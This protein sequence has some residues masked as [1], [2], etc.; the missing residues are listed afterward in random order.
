MREEKKI[1]KTHW[2]KGENGGTTRQSVGGPRTDVGAW[3]GA[4]F[5]SRWCVG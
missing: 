4:L 2:C 5:P 1:E 3:D